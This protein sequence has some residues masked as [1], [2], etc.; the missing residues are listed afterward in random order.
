VYPHN[1]RGLSEDI[2]YVECFNDVGNSLLFCEGERPMRKI[3]ADAAAISIASEL[4][5]TTEDGKI[6]ECFF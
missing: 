1:R 2:K 4:F 6:L 3:L 5:L